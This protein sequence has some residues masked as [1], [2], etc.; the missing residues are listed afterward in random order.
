M[1]S[2]RLLRI[3]TNFSLR[4]PDPI[5]EREYY[6]VRTERDPQRGPVSRSVLGVIVP[7]LCAM[8]V[9]CASVL[10]QSVYATLVTVGLLAIPFLPLILVG[11]ALLI[12]SQALAANLTRCLLYTSDA[13]DE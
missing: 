13:A 10:N 4:T 9:L 6:L 7:F 3:L 12:Y 11:G 8:W 5:F 2:W 1:T